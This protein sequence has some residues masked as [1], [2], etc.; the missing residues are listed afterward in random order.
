MSYNMPFRILSLLELSDRTVSIE[1]VIDNAKGFGSSTSFSAASA[2]S[3]TRRRKLTSTT[4]LSVIQ[5]ST[6]SKQQ[7]RK[8]HHADAN[9]YSNQSV[10]EAHSQCRWSSNKTNAEKNSADTSPIAAPIRRQSMEGLHSQLLMTQQQG[11]SETQPNHSTASGSEG[12]AR[13]RHL[14]RTVL[15]DL[16]QQ[17]VDDDN[18]EPLCM[19]MAPRSPHRSFT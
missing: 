13:A 9:K 6:K 2:N 4:R 10:A 11:T 19:D 18:D 12:I 5:A 14:I 16:D 15:L 17:H 1:L 7:R 8:H 3:R